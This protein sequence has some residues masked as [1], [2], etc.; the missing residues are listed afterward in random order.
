MPMNRF[1]TQPLDSP[2]SKQ[3]YR[4]ARILEGI[5]TLP[6]A[7]AHQID[8]GTDV[9]MDSPI[10]EARKEQAL[11]QHANAWSDFSTSLQLSLRKASPE[12]LGHIEAILHSAADA[13]NTLPEDRTTS[14]IEV[15]KEKV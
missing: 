4:L 12:S 14:P 11:N 9:I 1:E 2:E 5:R 3:R 8:R 7:L 13:L 10:S 15:P 6:E